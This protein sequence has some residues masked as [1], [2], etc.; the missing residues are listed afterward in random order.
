MENNKQ[1]TNDDDNSKKRDE[2]LKKDAR[3]VILG[4]MV[5][6]HFVRHS[7]FEAYQKATKKR[8]LELYSRIDFLLD[9]FHEMFQE[10]DKKNAS[11]TANPSQMRANKLIFY[12]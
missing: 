6:N 5:S 12:L 10:M 1:K 11:A 3:E 9:R 7:E 4:L 2:Q 8:F